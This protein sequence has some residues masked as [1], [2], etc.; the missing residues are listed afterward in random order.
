LAIHM[1]QPFAQSWILAGEGTDQTFDVTPAKGNNATHAEYRVGWKASD[2]KGSDKA[3]KTHCKS[4]TITNTGKLVCVQP[5]ESELHTR[6]MSYYIPDGVF[7]KTEVE[8]DALHATILFFDSSRGYT[9]DAPVVGPIS[10][11]ESTHERKPANLSVVDV[12][13]I[14]T[15][16]RSWE[17]LHETGLRF[18]DRGEWEE[19]LGS[20]RTALHMCHNNAWL[21]HPRYKHVSLGAIGKMYRMLGLYYQASEC[22]EDTVFNTPQTRFRIDCAG[23]LANV[24]RHMDR[25]DDCKRVA[26]DQYYGAKQLNL[27]KF[28]CRA[29]GTLGMVNYQLYLLNQDSSLLETA[30]SQL[31]E[32]V[33]RAQQIGDIVL[34]SIGYSRLSLC[35]MAK[36]DPEKAVQMGQKNF[37]LMCMQ[38]D[39]TKIGFAKAFLGR[40]LLFA[41]QKDKALELFDSPLGCPP[42]VA[43]CKEISNEHRQYI[44]EIIDAGANLKLRDKQG[45]SA[46]ECAVYNGD[47]ETTKII[48]QGLRAQISRER[49][50]VEEQLTQFQYEATLRKGYRYVFQDEL[51]PILLGASNSSTLQTLRQTYAASLA[52]DSEKRNTFDGLKYVTYDDFLRSG[53]LPRSDA[54]YTRESAKRKEGRPEPYI[55]FFS[56]RWIAK[57]PSAQTSIFS[58]D[59]EDRTQYKRMLSAVEQFLNLHRDVDRDQLCIWIVSLHCS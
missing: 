2:D 58:P 57:A 34:E 33:E 7:H 29:V 4:S 50:N 10:Q 55:L 28:A 1:H 40:A 19:A 27:D 49:G 59:D 53:Q 14:I 11:K 13:N 31:T 47:D 22:L 56:Y 36:G 42:I 5:R 39:T 25:L 54:G 37:D 26:Q 44:I 8:H 20:Y 24:Y 41:G 3:Y 46:L 48:E 6:N 15:N 30:I 52:E 35:Y 18:S 23:E 43:L 12:A 32:R 51:R 16:L 17:V 38:Q 45:Y 21:D 9:D